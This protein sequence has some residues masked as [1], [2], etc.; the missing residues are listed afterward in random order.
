M[1]LATAHAEKLRVSRYFLILFAA[2]GVIAAVLDYPT[3][4]YTVVVAGL[5]GAGLCP[6]VLYL[7]RIE[8]YAHLPRHFALFFMVFL[9]LTGVFNQLHRGANLVWVPIFPF[10]YFYLA[11]LRTGTMLSA[12]SFAILIVAYIIYPWLHA[13]S[14]VPLES[15]LQLASAFGFTSLFA[16]L[17]ERGRDR[18]ERLLLQQA[19]YDFLTGI[20][21]RRGLMQFLDAQLY[22]GARKNRPFSLLLVDLD[23]FK[24]VNDIHG[25][26]VG[27][28]VLKAFAKR[29]QTQLRRSDLLGRWGGEEFAVVLPDETLAGAVA[30]A[31]K[32]RHHVAE[33]PFAPIGRITASFGVAEYVLGENAALLIKRADSALYRAKHAGKNR[34]EA[35]RGTVTPPSF[36]AAN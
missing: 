28:E 6:L 2:F 25:H 8:R 7:S 13:E 23:D 9:F 29:L 4:N 24:T 11:G 5:A 15:F 34:T 16:Y 35:E 36:S 33:Q 18:Q 19:E 20:P 12:A 3:G 27:D 17:Y 10:G 32:L 22:L 30:V 31:E 1:R 26:D 14:R 21:N